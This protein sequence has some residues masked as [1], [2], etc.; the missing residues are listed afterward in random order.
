M[1]AERLARWKARQIPDRAPSG[2]AEFRNHT[3]PAIEANM[4]TV[5]RP[6]SAEFSHRATKRRI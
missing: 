6:G 3:P 2:W 5:D 1:R 4:P